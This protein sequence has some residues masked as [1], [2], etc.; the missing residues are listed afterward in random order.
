M[1]VESNPWQDTFM[2][3]CEI[4]R[5]EMQEHQVKI[6]GEFVSKEFMLTKLELSETLVMLYLAVERGDHTRLYNSIIR[7]YHKL[8]QHAATI[9]NYMI[10]PCQLR[11]D[12]WRCFSA[13]RIY[14]S[15]RKRVK[16]IMKHCREDPRRLMRPDP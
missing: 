7:T 16:A 13:T 12:S 8:Y 15:M 5:S 14:E 9:D 3:E 6:E 10:I 2:Q 11:L 1:S 4:L